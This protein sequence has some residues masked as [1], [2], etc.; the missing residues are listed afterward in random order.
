MPALHWLMDLGK[1][2]FFILSC[3]VYGI[4]MRLRATLLVMMITISSC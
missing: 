2:D 1:I 4:I 3:S